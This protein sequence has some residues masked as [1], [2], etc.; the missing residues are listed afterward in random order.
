MHTVPSLGPQPVHVVTKQSIACCSQTPIQMFGLLK[1]PEITLAAWP[2]KLAFQNGT[3]FISVTAESGKRLLK[4]LWYATSKQETV[5]K[6]VFL[7]LEFHFKLSQV[8][9]WIL[10]GHVGANLL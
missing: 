1:E 2:R 8:F 5:L 7:C 4:E 9:K 10:V 3:A 6:S